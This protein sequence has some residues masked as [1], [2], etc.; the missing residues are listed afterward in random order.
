MVS[1]SKSLALRASPVFGRQR[2]QQGWHQWWHQWNTR[3]SMYNIYIYIYINSQCVC[4]YIIYIY[5][6]TCVCVCVCR[7]MA[8]FSRHA[9]KEFRDGVPQDDSCVVTAMP[10]A[11]R[12]HRCSTAAAILPLLAAPRGKKNR[13]TPPTPAGCWGSAPD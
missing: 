4:V 7:Y 11:R 9:Q 12:H 5:V 10:T 3:N 8:K 2:A 1:G 13:Q 6:C